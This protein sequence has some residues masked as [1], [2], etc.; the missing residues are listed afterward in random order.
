MNYSHVAYHVHRRRA[1]Q[2]HRATQ[3][4]QPCGLS[5]QHMN[6]S[7]TAYHVQRRFTHNGTISPLWRHEEATSLLYH[8][9]AYIRL[10][11]SLS[12]RDTGHSPYQHMRVVQ[13]KLTNNLL[14]QWQTALQKRIQP[15]WTYFNN[16][17]TAPITCHG[18]WPLTTKTQGTALI[19][20]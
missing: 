17:G 12:R 4:F 11:Q 16:I 1:K 19:V 8:E 7:H 6:Y 9:Y 2:L 14:E 10:S 18:A 5:L 13:P 15:P 20:G 3:E